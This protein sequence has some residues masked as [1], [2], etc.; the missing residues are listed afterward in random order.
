MEQLLLWNLQHQCI[1]IILVQWTSFVWEFLKTKVFMK[2]M[3][4]PR[5]SRSNLMFVGQNERDVKE[6]ERLLMHGWST[7][8][9]LRLSKIESLQ[10]CTS[11]RQHNMVVLYFLKNQDEFYLILKWGGKCIK[12]KKKKRKLPFSLSQS[13]PARSNLM[14]QQLVIWDQHKKKNF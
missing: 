13:K 10:N 11:I 14:N 3:P 1:K 7:C 6:K 4:L 8:K 12:K 9:L 5:L 2:E